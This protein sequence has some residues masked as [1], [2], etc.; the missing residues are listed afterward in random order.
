METN[1]KAKDGL[2]RILK[3]FKQLISPVDTN[4]F[5]DTIERPE[6]KTEN[7]F[8]AWDSPDLIWQERLRPREVRGEEEEEEEG[9]EESGENER[10]QVNRIVDDPTRE[11][12]TG[13]LVKSKQ[14]GAK[15][16]QAGMKC[17]MDHFLDTS[18]FDRLK[19]RISLNQFSIAS[20]MTITDETLKALSSMHPELR[21]LDIS[22]CNKVSDQGL[23][24][25]STACGKLTELN[26]S[27]VSLVTSTGFRAIC[28]AATLLNV[29]LDDCSQV[30]DEFLSVLSA[31]CWSLQ[32]FSMSNNT[33]VTDNA[34]C[35][36]VQCCN[37]LIS[38]NLSLCKNVGKYGNIFLVCLAESCANLLELDVTGCS[39]LK[40]T[41]VSH[42]LFSTTLRG[43]ENLTVDDCPKLTKHMLRAPDECGV[44]SSGS[45]SI[46]RCNSSLKSLHIGGL[47]RFQEVDLSLLGGF[48]SLKHLSL[49]NSVF[50]TFEGLRHLFQGQTLCYHLT[51]LNIARCPKVN[52]RCL[53]LIGEHLLSLQ[54]LNISR[55]H[56][57]T[58]P[59]IE[60]L[61][62]KIAYLVH[63]DASHC[64][65]IRY[66]DLSALADRLPFVRIAPKRKGKCRSILLPVEQA[67]KL[68]KEYQRTLA[69]M[70]ATLTI[71]AFLR[72][73]KV[74]GGH[75]K[76]K[77]KKIRSWL[78]V[79]L[80]A[81][82]RGR[83]AQKELARRKGLQRRTEAAI[84]L[85]CFFRQHTA[86]DFVRELIARQASVEMFRRASS[87]IA[88]VYRCHK[89][90]KELRTRQQVRSRQQQQFVEKEER[91]KLAAIFI[92]RNLRKAAALKIRRA[93]E[94][95]IRA[96][97]LHQA[98][99]QQQATFIQSHVRCYLCRAVVPLLKAVEEAQLQYIRRVICVQNVYR[100]KR[101]K[102][103]FQHLIQLQQY[104]VK[105]ASAIR[106]Q[107]T[108][109]GFRAKQLAA[110]LKS[111]RK[112]QM[113]E[114]AF[115]VV[116]QSHWRRKLA[117]KIVVQRREE[118]ALEERRS[119][120]ALKIQRAFNQ[121]QGNRRQRLRDSQ[122]E[123]KRKKELLL[124]K[125]AEAQKQEQQAR[126]RVRLKEQQV[127]VMRRKLKGLEA[128]LSM[129]VETRKPTYDS[130]VV[131]GAP[132]RY[133]T[134][135]LARLLRLQLEDYQVELAKLEAGMG[136]AFQQV[137]GAQKE[138]QTIAAELSDAEKRQ[139]S[140]T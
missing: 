107:K 103:V 4:A 48:T 56:L 67:G 60:G 11:L 135:E 16:K 115:A 80:Q 134:K 36:F 136:Y 7:V 73:L 63:L 17:F 126:S 100:A 89:A 114:E 68:I 34:L 25:L 105:L 19:S 53:Q 116:I 84:Q 96:E 42:L 102:K 75:R 24:Y 139:Y 5:S 59:G 71:Q 79:R 123:N 122:V 29:K 32:S 57:V 76:I 33:L 85:Q 22:G 9:D 125:L 133:E 140:V 92:Q 21:G 13:S 97:K 119:E 28:L 55:D 86:L 118:F 38:L 117:S 112:L 2:Q 64:G 88:R 20:G 101:A 61:F 26:L 120:A 138:V 18:R 3:A 98:L 14:P 31:A 78:T 66:K 129:V 111:L 87:C 94:G 30:D 23:F 104:R 121:H 15:N 108:W 65:R 110:L 37:K 12:A 58:V 124:H 47:S 83:L 128:E 35:N 137:T 69:E 41:G 77:Q 6:R 1:W 131:S 49:R 8:P 72:H 74:R 45:E 90:R 82:G 27:K 95:R 127:N 130:S 93:L 51:R 109:R 10:Q 43:L 44:R 46:P 99:Q 62:S 40:S 91:M 54:S 106:I 113:F 39:E 132:Q 52:D 70:N 50:L 81:I